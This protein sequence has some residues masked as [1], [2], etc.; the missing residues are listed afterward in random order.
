MQLEMYNLYIL[1]MYDIFGVLR[2]ER[3]SN[4]QSR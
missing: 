1:Y 2:A 4:A 3:V